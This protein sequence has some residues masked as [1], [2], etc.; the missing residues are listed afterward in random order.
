[1][2]SKGQAARGGGVG[3]DGMEG[4]CW[5]YPPVTGDKMGLRCLRQSR[6]GWTHRRGVFC[7]KTLLQ[8]KRTSTGPPLDTQ[9]TL[10][11]PTKHAHM[12]RH[13]A[14]LHSPGTRRQG[15]SCGTRGGASPP[16]QPTATRA[17]SSAR[18][19]APQ[20]SSSACPQVARLG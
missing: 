2:T 3:W 13:T 1:M 5:T 8:S 4:A 12:V 18:G 19:T 20:E 17:P 16:R 10:I 14:S 9:S 6:R 15:S 11:L 7:F